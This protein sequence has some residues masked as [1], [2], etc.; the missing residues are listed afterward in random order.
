MHICIWVG[1]AIADDHQPIIQIAGVANGR[2]HDAAGVDTGEHQRV[3]AV[4]AQLPTNGLM[5]CLTTIGSPSR[6]A[7]ARWI[8]APSLP[9]TAI[10]FAFSA[11]NR[12]LR[13]LTSGWPSRNAT[14][15]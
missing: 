9:A 13:G 8:A 4:G 11:L 14:T 5:R 1:A 12:G 3:D 10:P 6:A 15:T 7:A 2:Q